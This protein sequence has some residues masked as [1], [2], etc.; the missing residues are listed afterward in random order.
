M[1]EAGASERVTIGRRVPGIF[2]FQALLSFALSIWMFYPLPVTRADWTKAI[3]TLA[4]LWLL[5]AA[6]FVLYLNGRVSYT[7]K[8]RHAESH[9]EH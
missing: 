8:L 3:A 5:T 2:K 9:V 6:V 7:S 1:D 4:T